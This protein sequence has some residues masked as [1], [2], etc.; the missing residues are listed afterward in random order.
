MNPVREIRH[1]WNRI[2]R[3]ALNFD[4]LEADVANLTSVV[5][6]VVKLLTDLAQEI[7]DSAGNAAKAEELATKIEASTSALAAAAQ[8]NTPAD[9]NAPQG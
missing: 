6:G 9:P 7:R 4:R 8:A 5:D 2:I 1:L 3:M